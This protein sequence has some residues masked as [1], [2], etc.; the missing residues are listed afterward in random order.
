M[1]S[2]LGLKL[3]QTSIILKTMSQKGKTLCSDSENTGSRCNFLQMVMCLWESL[4]NH[5]VIKTMPTE[6]LLN[7]CPALTSAFRIV[8]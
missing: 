5:H 6:L 7:R 1:M 2:H 8:F 4:C 3:S